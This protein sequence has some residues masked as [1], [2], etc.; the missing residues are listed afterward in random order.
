MSLETLLKPNVREAVPFFNVKDM[1][2][3]LRFY[4]D[5]LGFRIT[6][7]WT[8][9]DPSVIRWCRLQHGKAGLML[10]TYWRDGKPGGWPEG[11][12]GQGVSVCFMC[13]DALALMREASQRGLAPSRN[14]FVGNKMWV[15]DYVDPDGYRIEFESPTSVPEETEYDPAKHD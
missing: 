15:V 6:H 2:A 4:V 11:Q 13:D 8:P 14:P 9:D 5:G 12:L 3:S 1:P 7:D 10:Q